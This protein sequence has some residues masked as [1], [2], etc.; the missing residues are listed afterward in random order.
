MPQFSEFSDLIIEINNVYTFFNNFCNRIFIIRNCMKQ[1]FDKPMCII[2][3][4]VFPSS[5]IIQKQMLYFTFK[6]EDLMVCVLLP[7]NDL[8][9]S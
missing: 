1:E 3:A 4:S 6:Y 9:V 5:D 2:R 7:Y 8:Y